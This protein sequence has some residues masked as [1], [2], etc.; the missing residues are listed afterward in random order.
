MFQTSQMHLGKFPVNFKT[1][2]CSKSAG[3]NLT[4][5]WIKEVEIAKS[6]DDLMASRSITMRTD[7]TDYDVFDAMIASAWKKQFAY[8]ILRALRALSSHWSF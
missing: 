3:P 4:M 7:F 2:V 6:I 8:M 1:E 5:Q